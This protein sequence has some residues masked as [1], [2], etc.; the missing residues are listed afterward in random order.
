MG[1]FGKKEEE[2]D[3]EGGYS[4]EEGFSEEEELKDRK[5]TRKCRDLHSENKKKRKEPP[6]PW[7]KK[8]CYIVLGFFLLTTLLA[9]GMFLFSHDFKFPGLPRITIGSINLKNPFGEEIIEIGQKGQALQSDANAQRAISLFNSEIEPVSGYYGFLVIRLADGTSYGVSSD[10]KFQGAS[11]LKLPLVVMMYK[12]AEDGRLNL[13]TKYTLKDADKVKSSGVLYMAKSG[14]IYTYR[15]LAELMGKDSDRTA[16]KV[17]KD[18]VG[19]T[20]FKNYL[21]E[22]GMKNTDI[23]TGNTTPNDIGLIFQKLWSGSLVNQT[24]RDEILGF[25][26]NTIYEKWITAGVPKDV[27]VAHKFGQDAGVMADGGIVFSKKPYVLVI[28]GQGI[29]QY[30]ADLL[31]PKVSKDVYDAENGVR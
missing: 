11:L 13:D 21:T 15:Q 6:K 31:F 7:G 14:N 28:M 25:L 19:D 1:L 9:M 26:K 18:V 17:I 30:D 20:N 8:E 5:L 10:G 12:M 2:F 23:D 4:E 29:T 16:Y 24:D 27:T 3:T 22:I